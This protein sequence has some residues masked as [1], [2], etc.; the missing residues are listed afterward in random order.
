MRK[1][2]FIS[3]LLCLNLESA[4]TITAHA[5]PL[6]QEP[7]RIL[8]QIYVES[9]QDDALDDGAGDFKGVQRRLNY[10]KKLGVGGLLLMP[11]FDSDGMG[12]IPH[13]FFVMRRDY[14][15]SDDSLQ[16]EQAFRRLTNAAH[17]AGIKIFLDSPINHIDKGSDWFKNSA[18]RKPGFENDF[19]WADKPKEGWKIP[20]VP[21]SK[22]EDVWHFDDT[23]GQF[24]YALFGWGMP[25]LNHTNPTVQKKLDSFFEKYSALGVDGFRID[26][27]RHLIEGE[28][29]SDFRFPANLE[30]LRNYLTTLRKRHPDQS[31][32]HEV[33][34]NDEDIELYIR[35]AG[36]VAFDFPFMETL[37]D[38]VLHDHPWAVRQ[39]L[40][41]YEKTQ[42][43]Y[44][45]GSR[46]LFPG[47][48][49]V[50][51]IRTAMDNDSSRVELAMA[52]TL[53][54][55]FIPQLYYGD[56]IYMP[57]EYFRSEVPGKTRNEVCTPMAWTPGKNAGF[58]RP[59][60]ELGDSWNRKIHSDWQTF[61]VET[62]EKDPAS[63]LNLVKELA[64]VR[65]SLGIDNRTRIIVDASV[66]DDVVL[67]FAL[68]FPDGRCAVALYN[69]SNRE[70]K[71]RS[72]E[73]S[74]ACPS[75]NFSPLIQRR[76]RQTAPAQVNLEAHGI[77]LGI[78]S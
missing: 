17:R 78:S 19:V 27:A 15:G 1:L 52:L 28:T 38:S 37:R 32:L 55:P 21:T 23:R 7:S 34:S 70:Q 47:N 11:I 5:A 25:D 9:F 74:R 3:S 63:L 39:T 64:S 41:H 76:A 49:D 59:E 43:Q 44:P 36:D 60:F 4:F 45:P 66:P 69:F 67:K 40:D 33:W 12:Y 65:A 46:I 2:I 30:L 6:S 68:T 72:A 42:D 58:T 61:N 54:T 57:G 31:F 10:L 20:W 24:Y 22:P 56:E 18:A 35:D 50:P 51:R 75:K 26:A 48:H 8:Y 73:F 62:Q 53:T 16:R 71:K 77:W 29:N 13:D 14:G